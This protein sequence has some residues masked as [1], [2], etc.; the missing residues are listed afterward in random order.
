MKL[1]TALTTLVCSTALSVA[2]PAKES[3]YYRITTFPIPA[4][5]AIEV[6]SMELLPDGKVALGTRR[7]DIFLASDVTGRRARSVTS[8]SP[9]DSANCSD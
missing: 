1:F 4:D 7:G 3:D 6:G 8:C 9:P 2:E 5:A